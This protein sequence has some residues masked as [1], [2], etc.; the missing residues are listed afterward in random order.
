MVIFFV[1]QNGAGAVELF[2]EDE[3]HQLV[4][5]GELGEGPVMVRAGKDR[6]VQSINPADKKDEVFAATV[7]AHLDEMRKVF[8]G[9]LLPAF[10]KRYKKII[11]CKQRKKDL[12]FLF[13]EI[14]SRIFGGWD[15]SPFSRE[16][17]A[18]PAGKIIHARLYISV[19]LL[20]D[21]PE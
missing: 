21:R 6:G 7:S 19:I 1:A 16:V 5:K 20:A 9:E 13:F 11:F 3:S 8:G 4:R 12:S 14:G 17:S 10:V 15:Q 2:G 18:K